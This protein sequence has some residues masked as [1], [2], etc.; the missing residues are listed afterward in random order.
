MV[1]ASG[2]VSNDDQGLVGKVINTTR[3][4]GA[5]IGAALLPAVAAVANGGEVTGAVGDRATMLASG[6]AAAVATV[7]AWRAFGSAPPADLTS[8]DG[9]GIAA[10][11]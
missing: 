4:I 3:Q 1:T 9:K 2:G 7:V 11:R 8:T 10:S 6:L 5:A